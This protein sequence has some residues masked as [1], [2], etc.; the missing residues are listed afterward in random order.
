MKLKWLLRWYLLE[1]D[2]LNALL[3]LYL[4]QM[5]NA[6]KSHLLLLLMNKMHLQNRKQRSLVMFLHQNIEKNPAS[7][8]KLPPGNWHRKSPSLFPIKKER[9]YFR[10]EV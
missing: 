4:E 3:T 8:S 10:V 5:I 1:V 2:I 6:L 7:R 9:P